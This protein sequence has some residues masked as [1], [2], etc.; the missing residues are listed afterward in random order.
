MIIGIGTDIASIVRFQENI[1]K[2]GERF[3][4]KIL[5]ESEKPF[6]EQSNQKAQYLASRFAAKESLAKALGTGFR[7]GL[8]MPEIA[9]LS[10]E[11]GRPYFE[12]S[13]GAQELAT[14]LG[15]KSMHLSISH[16]KEFALAFVVLS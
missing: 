11:M 13:G 5:A 7:D 3:L 12:L 16:E 4:G 1:E 2:H 8:I 14:S 6:Y 15:V 10:N 9:I